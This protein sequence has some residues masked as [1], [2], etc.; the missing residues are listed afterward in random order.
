[1]KRNRRIQSRREDRIRSHAVGI[2]IT[3]NCRKEN[4]TRNRE[5][6]RERDRRLVRRGSSVLQRKLKEK[7]SRKKGI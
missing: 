6:R 7:E 1:M 3:D 2:N 5:R 4:R